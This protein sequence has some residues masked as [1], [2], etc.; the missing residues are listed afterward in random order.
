MGAGATSGCDPPPR[1]PGGVPCRSGLRGSLSAPL[2]PLHGPHPPPRD[3]STL[4]PDPLSA[5]ARGGVSYLVH[6]RWEER[7][8][9]TCPVSVRGP[10]ECGPVRFK[11]VCPSVCLEWCCPGFHPKF[12]PGGCRTQVHK[13]EQPLRPTPPHRHSCAPP[14]LLSRPPSPSGLGRGPGPHS[15]GRA[16]PAH[17]AA[18]RRAGARAGRM[19]GCLGA[20]GPR[21]T[22]PRGPRACTR[23]SPSRWPL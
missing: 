10:A 14:S 11:P 19:L 21:S 8:P 9:P 13:T 18:P 3:T 22:L 15:G 7:L 23:R 2:H 16:L 12:I 20:L 5:P 1:P 4:W 6:A 17:A